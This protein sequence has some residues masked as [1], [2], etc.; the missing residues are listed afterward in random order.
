M[1]GQ[2]VDTVTAEEFMQQVLQSV[3][4]EE[5]HDIA[6]ALERKA[7]VFGATFSGAPDAVASDD[8]LL[9]TLRLTFAAR[10]KA[11]TLVE[12][13]GPGRLGAL[14]AA[15][16]GPGTIPARIDGFVGALPGFEAVATEVA[17][18][19]LHFTMPERYWLWTRW[20][21]DPR[22]ETGALRLVT[23]DE[24]DLTG[25]S[26][27]E[28]YLMVG[29]AV[30]FV[31]ETGRAVGFAPEAHGTL[32]LDVFLACVYGIYMYT[33]LRMRMTQEFNQIVPE[34]PELAR[35]LLGVWSIDGPRPVTGAIG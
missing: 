34:L 6:S 11:P 8:E 21:W 7:A 18:E 12:A 3:S 4:R 15:L 24:V 9:G 32:G 22:T 35:R 17:T 14:A 28:T 1:G 30:A 2:V 5:L 29:E 26:P 16:F 25:N 10:R 19:I 33:V 31:A 23:M 27:G 13:A 20:M